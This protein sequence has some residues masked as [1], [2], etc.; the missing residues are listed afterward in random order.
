MAGI[1]FSLERFFKPGTYTSTV[2]AYLTAAL[3]FSGPWI[4]SVAG[5]LVLRRI[6]EAHL[7]PAETSYFISAMTYSFCFS[8]I[9]TGLSHLALVRALYDRVYSGDLEAVRPLYTLA[10]LAN[11]GLHV[12][13]AAAF[14]LPQAVPFAQKLWMVGL[15]TALGLNGQATLFMGAL[16]HHLFVL[17]ALV[18][19][20]ALG[21]ASGAILAAHG[22]LVGVISGFA[23]GMLASFALITGKLLAE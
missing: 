21:L 18:G 19:G 4:L 6:C 1:G 3:L 14:W 20:H 23:G 22:S 9:L 12:V 7:G 10:V 16:S 17:V 11:G 2:G 13:V 5:A 8:M 15:F